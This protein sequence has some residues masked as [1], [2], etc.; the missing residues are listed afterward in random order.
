[1]VLK[2]T[3]IAEKIRKLFSREDIVLN[4]KINN[5][6]QDIRFKNLNFIVQVD[7]R[8]Y[9]DYD[10]DD[11]KKREDMFKRHNFKIIRCNPNDPEFDI[12]KFLDEINSCVTKLCREKSVN[13]VINKIAEDFEKIVLVTKS[14][15]LKRYAKKK[16][17]EIPKNEKH[18]IKNKTNKNQKTTW[19]TYC[20]GCK[21][22][23][24]NFRP[25]KVKMT[26]TVLREKSHSV[27]CR[28]N[29]SR[30]LKQKVN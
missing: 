14:K 26:K 10:T 4:K 5:R 12:N 17:Y 22:F 1:M 27:A 15:E 20:F 2:E 21:D 18:T 28:S 13:K 3:S 19:N 30:F 29:K 23:T 6:K 24:H 7:E 8:N 9:E 11:E 16:V 25:E